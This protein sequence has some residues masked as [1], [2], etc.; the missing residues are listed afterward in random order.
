MTALRE[1]HDA[2]LFDLDGTLF[3]GGTALP[4]APEALAEAAGLGCRIGYL[5][6]NGS[7]NGGQVVDHLRALGFTA[8]ESEV[9]T[10]GQ[11]AA[12]LLV[13]RL[14]PGDAVVV[15]GSKALAGEVTSAGLT[16]ADRAE[17]AVAVLQGHSPDTGWRDLA[18]ACLAIRAGA[19]WVAT[20]VDATLPDERGELPGNGAMVAALVTATESQ[21]L[22]AGKPEAALF[23]EAVRRAAS[24]RPLMVGDRL[25][26][27][28]AGA[29]GVQMPSLLVLTGVSDA[30]AL[31]AA[32]EVDRPTY[33]GADLSALR[34]DPDRLRP[35]A[36]APWRAS[37]AGDELR[38]ELDPGAERDGA[39]DPIDALRTLCAAHWAS[40]GGR[41]SR[42]T[43]TGPAAIEAL[44]SLRLAAGG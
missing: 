8:D 23:H 41:P 5:T 12:R 18:E 25:E 2:L 35:I 9:V 13:D 31:L 6:N 24:E 39:D 16:V 19:L 20:N 4:G 29:N 3:R 14:K 7:R 42:I 26:T 30:A 36:Q 40:G 38:L 44:R 22:V 27:D 21:P 34:T 1:Q 11:A 10:S 28:I 32:P 43:A 37:R 17:Q 15:V 33:I